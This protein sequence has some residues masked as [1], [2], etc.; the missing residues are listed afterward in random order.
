MTFKEIL[1]RAKQGDSLALK[2]ILDLYHQMLVRNALINGRFDEDLYQELVIETIKC[3][4]YFNIS[5]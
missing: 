4:Q 3:I 2:Q 1:F 5:E